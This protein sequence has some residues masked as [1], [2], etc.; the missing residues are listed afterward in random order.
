MNV[1]NAA[2]VLSV[3]WQKRDQKKAEKSTAHAKNEGGPSWNSHSQF[4][5]TNRDH[6]YDNDDNDDEDD[7]D[8]IQELDESRID[9][10]FI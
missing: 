10:L 8:W 6:T 1:R 7:F 4:V 2:W 3:M 9:W 5:N